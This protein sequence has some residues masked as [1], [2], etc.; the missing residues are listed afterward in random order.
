VAKTNG[1]AITFCGQ[2]MNGQVKGKRPV[3]QLTSEG[4]EQGEGKVDGPMG[5]TIGRSTTKPNS[6]PMANGTKIQTIIQN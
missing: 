1:H 4:V 3:G 2:E 5:G 6:K